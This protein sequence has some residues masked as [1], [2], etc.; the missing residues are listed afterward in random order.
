M[1]TEPPPTTWVLPDPSIVTTGGLGDLDDLVAIGADLEPGTLLSAYRTGLFPMP[2]PRRDDPAYWFCPVERGVLPLDCLQVSRSLRRSA[3]DFEIRVNT[4][5]DEVVA[6]CADPR[7]PQ[8]WID[9]D[10]RRA[11][12]RL[13]ELGWAHSVETWRDGRLV[14][15]LYGVA[16]GGLFAGE[17]M[18]HRE[19]DASKVALLGLV[20]LLR[21]EHAD[22]RLIDVQWQT[23]HLESMGVMEVPRASY[24]SM[25]PWVLDVP[26]PE[27]FGGE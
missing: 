13:H 20:E 2:G 3:R 12:G 6:G 14:G 10:I 24:L 26:L 5:F 18:F 7:R 27:V 1:P 15:G 4:A 17:S 16:L 23:P 19:R 9:R 22:R 21:D 11:Y 25:L 8:G